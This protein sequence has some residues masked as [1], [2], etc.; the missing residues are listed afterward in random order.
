MAAAGEALDFDS[1][2]HTN[3]EYS[4]S[5]KM[6]THKKALLLRKNAKL[7]SVLMAEGILVAPIRDMSPA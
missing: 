5:Q 2:N 3:A 6:R 4:G 1:S 7:K